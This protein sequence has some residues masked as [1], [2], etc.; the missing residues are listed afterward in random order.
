[1]QSA[2]DGAAMSAATAL[3]FG[4]PT[5]FRME[6]KAVS[7]KDGFTDGVDGTTVTINSPPANGS[8]AGD[9]NAVEAII[10]QPQTLNLI[11]LFRSGLFDVGARAVAVAEP[12]FRYCFL[13]LDLSAS[14]AFYVQNNAIVSNPNCGVVVDSSA[15]DALR[16]RN[17]AEIN[18]PTYVHGSWDLDVNAQ[19]NGTPNV[20]DG[21]VVDDPYADVMLDPIPACTGQSGTAS[22]GATVN[23]TP[24]NFCDGFN[25]QNNVTVN[26]APGAYY[27]DSQFRAQNNVIING[28]G[29]VTLIITG[30]YALDWGNGLTINL[31]APTTGTY[32]GIALFGPR[33]GPENVVQDIDNNTTADIQGA[34]YFPSQIL[35]I[36]N[37]G[38]T[39][40]AQCTQ[41]IARVI[42]IYNNAYANNDCDGTGARPFG[43][44]RSELVE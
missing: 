8:Y 17:N 43:P 12:G 35:S 42:R 38:I 36:H 6:G 7:A 32:A 5:D 33:D 41:I 25:F 30:D 9:P 23:L 31:V 26:L 10:S 27:I 28:T 22:N 39:G 13:S 37:N 44:G 29:G 16:M 20:Q 24:G 2:A 1:M 21:P 40:S 18:G 19:L 4:Y 11:K 15:G 34:I 3:G 14:E